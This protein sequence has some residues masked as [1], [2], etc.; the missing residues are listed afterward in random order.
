MR[1]RGPTKQC[2]W[3]GPHRHPC[4][5]RRRYADADTYGYDDTYGHPN[6]NRNS[7]TDRY[8]TRDA[9]TQ[10]RANRKAASHSRASSLKGKAIYRKIGTCWHVVPGTSRCPPFREGIPVRIAKADPPNEFKIL[11]TGFA[12]VS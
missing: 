3:L 10:V 5:C 12:G 4:S 2:L 8:T 9:H 11:L 1:R 6:C 7:I